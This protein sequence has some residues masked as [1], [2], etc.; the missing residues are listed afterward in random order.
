MSDEEN[1]R[2]IS[3]S[4]KPRALAVIDGAAR[5]RGLSRSR[6]MTLAG[7]LAADQIQDDHEPEPEPE[8]A[9]P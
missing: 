7:L 8:E 5:K 2:V 3:I 1:V 4:V 6:F 9:S